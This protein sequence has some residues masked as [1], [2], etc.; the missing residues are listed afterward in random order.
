G[1][2]NHGNGTRDRGAN[3]RVGDDF[4]ASRVDLEVRLRSGPAALVADI[5]GRAVA[6]DHDAVRS[7]ADADL[8]NLLR[9]LRGQVDLGER[10]VLVQ[11]GIGARAILGERDPAGVGSPR[12]IEVAAGSAIIAHGAV[13]KAGDEGVVRRHADLGVVFQ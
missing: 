12:T 7:V 13:R 6:G 1:Q 11:Q 3:Y 9:R 8:L 4:S 5:S 10:I 2:I